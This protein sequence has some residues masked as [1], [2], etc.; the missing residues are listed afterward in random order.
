MRTSNP[1]LSQNR[2]TVEGTF[3]TQKM[4]I[5]GVVNKTFIMFALVL[6]SSY[7]VWSK[8]NET[9]IAADIGVYM[10]VGIIGGLVVA[11]ITVF[12][13]TVSAITAPIYALLE[14]LA[15]GGISA[16]M[17][18]SYPG[19][20]VQAVSLTFAVFFSLLFVYRTGLIKVTEK[21]RLMV[22]AATGGI[23]LVYMLSFILGFFSIN[24]PF[25]HE[26]GLIGIG[27][28]LVVIAVAAMNLVLDFDFIER[29]AE[30]GFP[31]HMEWYASFGLMVTL[32]WLYLEILRLLSKLRSR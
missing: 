15:L 6:A 5:D 4:T 16:F 1:V 24:I 26:S 18:S 29:G 2:F 10:M 31:K 19:I 11:I 3:T 25:I 23:F 12:K 27:F 9:M 22:V 28:S 30:K 8:F 17:E 13:P 14:G 32:I 7:W 21:F 20:V